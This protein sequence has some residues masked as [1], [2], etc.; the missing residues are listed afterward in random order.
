MQ[1]PS[2][3]S[4]EQF[5][6]SLYSLAENCAYGELRDEMIRECIVV[7]I[8]NGPLSERLQLDSELTL[9]KVKTLL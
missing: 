2:D 9:E 3:E 6:T 8:H 5:I 7:G 4:A 1:P